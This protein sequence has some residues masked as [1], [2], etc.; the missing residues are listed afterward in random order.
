MLFVLALF[1]AFGVA[2]A[3]RV[4]R[5]HAPSNLLVRTVRSSPPRWR[6][7]AG[8]VAASVVLLIAIH[9]LTKVIAQGASGWLNLLVLLLAWDSIK[10]LFLGLLVAAQCVCGASRVL[11]ER[12][13]PRDRLLL[14]H[15][16][17]STPT[18]GS[19]LRQPSDVLVTTSPGVRTALSQPLSRNLWAK[20]D[21][22]A[23]PVRRF[24]LVLERRRHSDPLGI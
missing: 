8:T 2:F 15:R 11:Q 10:L 7:V 4:V 22:E 6:V 24:G 9:C 1:V 20:V 12:S 16:A 19:R 13:S 21:I 14:V 23:E 3:S 18:A 17:P 5:T